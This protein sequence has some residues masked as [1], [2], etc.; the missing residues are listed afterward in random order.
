MGESGEKTLRVGVIFGGRSGEHE[1]SLV[2]AR[3]VI[4]AMNPDRYAII[5][6][7]IAKDGRWLT[8][9]EANILLDGGMERP[10][11]QGVRP[12][13][14]L[15]DPGRGAL[16]EMQDD[17]GRECVARQVGLDVL[18]PVLHGPYGEDGTLQ[19]LL[20]LANLPYVGAGVLASALAMDKA[21]A[22]DVFRARG[23]PI[24]P[25]IVVKRKEWWAEPAEVIARVEACIGYDCFVKPACLGS[26]VG[27]T[28]AHHR[29]ELH[30]ALDAAAAYDRKI[31]V[32]EAIAAREI[33]VSVLGNDDPIA[34][35]PGEIIP[36]REFYDYKAKYVED[37]SELLIPAPI[38]E[39]LSEEVRRLA[40]E[41]YLAL[42]CAGM[43]RVDFLLEK[44]TDRLYLNE[45]NTI[46]GFTSI[47]MYPKLWEASGIP[48]AELIDRLIALALE[49]HADKSRSRTS[50]DPELE[51]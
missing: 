22:K 11:E 2:S 13:A 38:D 9:D 12:A 44:G 19:G 10:L 48:Y 30:K 18:F 31:V 41:A 5:P 34:S 3:S 33:E 45:I 27:I 36:C 16:L 49:R 40:I 14:L 8:A 46:P 15:A 51:G 7:G 28:K 4:S 24:V 25:H 23:F 26:S 29:E 43:A 37:R 50:Y 47:S 6:I 17:Q 20:E 32:E 39:G 42:D 35:M 1:V 21:A